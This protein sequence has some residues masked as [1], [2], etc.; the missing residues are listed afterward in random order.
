MPCLV[1]L[2]LPGP[3]QGTPTREVL[4]SW[5]W[6]D[7]EAPQVFWAQGCRPSIHTHSNRACLRGFER[8]MVSSQCP[9]KSPRDPL[10]ALPCGNS[11]DSLCLGSNCLALNP[12]PTATLT[13]TLAFFS[14]CA[15]ST[16]LVDWTS[17]GSSVS[18][19]SV[20]K[21]CSIWAVCFTIRAKLS[22]AWGGG[23]TRSQNPAQG[24]GGLQL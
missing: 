6:I 18:A 11:P 14:V 1:K 16:R 8:V 2:E 9:I 13:F 15:L 3:P 10:L 5:L 12:S 22:I 17:F 21:A 24:R 7:S 20:P 4:W 19:S 23:R